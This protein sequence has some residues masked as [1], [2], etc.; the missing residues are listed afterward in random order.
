MDAVSRSG[1]ANR[2][3]NEVSKDALPAGE[4]KGINQNH[5]AARS[6]KAA[7]MGQQ[8]ICM[9]RTQQLQCRMAIA[10]P[11]RNTDNERP[12]FH[13]N[14]PGTAAPPRELLSLCKSSG[15]SGSPALCCAPEKP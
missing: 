13:W 3:D 2:E 9:G 4:M 5:R 1:S 8:R 11:P 6:I 14:H 12:G 7:R 10:A 15:F